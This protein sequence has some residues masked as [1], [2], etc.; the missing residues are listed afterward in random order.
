MHIILTQNFTSIHHHY[1]PGMGLTSNLW[2]LS[3][4]YDTLTT[5]LRLYKIF[6]D[7]PFLVMESFSS[8]WN[9]PCLLYACRSFR[10]ALENN[11][12][13][14]FTNEGSRGESIFSYV[15]ATFSNKIER[16]PIASEGF[17]NESTITLI[18]KSYFLPGKEMVLI[19]AIW[20]WFSWWKIDQDLGKLSALENRTQ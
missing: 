7:N 1:A 19:S 10:E 4:S 20:L 15:L 9:S 5:E 12:W 14:I 18:T 11:S 17:L 16:T 6:H 8:H 3:Q 2:W 13:T